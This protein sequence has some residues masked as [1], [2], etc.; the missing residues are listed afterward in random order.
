MQTTFP[1]NPL[2][3]STGIKDAAAPMHTAFNHD[4]S[5]YASNC[6]A[7]RRVIETLGSALAG[8]GKLAC[9]LRYGRVQLGARRSLL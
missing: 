7:D 5:K 8:S 2:G 1:F 6:E 3:E 4:F 9:H